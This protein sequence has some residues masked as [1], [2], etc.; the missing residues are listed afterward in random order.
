MYEDFPQVFYH[1]FPGSSVNPLVLFFCVSVC[2]CF[3]LVVTPYFLL[4]ISFFL[5]YVY[6]VFLSVV[7][8]R[9]TKRLFHIY[10]CSFSLEFIW[11]LY[12]LA[13]SDLYPLPFY[14]FVFTDCPCLYCEFVGDLTHSFMIFCVLFQ[15]E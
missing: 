3:C 8:I 15:V 7:M 13:S 14:V 11:F 10:S 6:Q 9:F 5:S 1:L 12:F 4:L 2:F